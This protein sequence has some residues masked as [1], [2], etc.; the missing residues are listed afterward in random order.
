LGL[1][2]RLLHQSGVGGGNTS[3]FFAAALFGVIP[4]PPTGILCLQG[5]LVI[6]VLRLR[7]RPSRHG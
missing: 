3:Q 2:V 5:L 6:V 7:Q 1:V 4:E